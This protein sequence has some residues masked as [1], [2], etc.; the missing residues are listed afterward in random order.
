MSQA[1]AALVQNL[2]DFDRAEHADVAVV[3]AAARHGVDVRA[4]H[5]RRKLRVAAVATADDVARRVD[6]HD[7]S[8]LS[9][10]LADVFAARDIGCAE[11]DAAHAAF[12][13]GAEL[14]QLGDAA[15]QP[16]FVRGQ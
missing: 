10:E 7:E 4:R 3:V 8:G 2:R 14:R 16:C 15:L 11:R 5:D 6:A 13:V 9:H 1:N 12:R